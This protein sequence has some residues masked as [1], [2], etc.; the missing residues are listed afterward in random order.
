MIQ[1]TPARIRAVGVVAAAAPFL[2]L[3]GARA[4]DPFGGPAV[5]DAA[6]I[7]DAI[8]LEAAPLRRA[9]KPTDAERAAVAGARALAEEPTPPTPFYYAPGTLREE[10]PVETVTVTPTTTRSVPSFQVSAILSGAGAPIAVINGKA[11]RVG[12]E[13]LEGWMLVEV[14]EAAREVVIEHTDGGRLRV[15]IRR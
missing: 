15:P 4:L 1:I 10:T 9:P 2:A 11:L 3:L 13:I 6:S 5:A 8:E 7:T 14:H 12:Q